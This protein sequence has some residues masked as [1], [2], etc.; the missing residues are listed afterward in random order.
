MTGVVELRQFLRGH[1]MIE[2]IKEA[3][4]VDSAFVTDAV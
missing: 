3:E 2:V 1:C 4:S